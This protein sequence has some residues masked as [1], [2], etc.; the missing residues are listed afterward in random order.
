MSEN[1]SKNS[2]NNKSMTVDFLLML[3]V[4]LALAVRFYGAR[5]LAIAGVSVATAVVCDLLGGLLL[6]DKNSSDLS[7]VLTGLIIALMMPSTV[8]LYIPAFASSFAV[9][10]AATPFGGEN[11]TP[12]VPSAAGFAFAAICFK[13]AVFSYTCEKTDMTSTSIGSLL[14]EG[15]SL[16]VNSVNIIDILCGNIV[17]PMGTGCIIVILAC[18]LFILIR[19]RKAL[20][21]TISFIL[22]VAVF[23]AIFPR[24]NAGIFTNIFL[25]LCSG[26][27][28]FA[29][30]FL[31]T[32]YSSTPRKYVNKA[33]YGIF[34]GIITM[35]MRK[36]GA[37]EEPVCFAVIL[38]N[39]F[40]P[41]LDM[42]T[43]RF[44]IITSGRKKEVKE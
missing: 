23:A 13:D 6:K 31:L 44:M 3:L 28:L 26:S 43:E 5:A 10:V 34:C 14:A 36:F 37:F 38:S 4:P 42:L 7:A 15:K 27:L 20:I 21:A 2:I 19:K 41:L 24:T 32:D 11:K 9:I 33:V 8:P 1:K 29:A 35:V 17:G 40:S 18:C 16:T 22:T 39:A 25:E 30:V 12:F